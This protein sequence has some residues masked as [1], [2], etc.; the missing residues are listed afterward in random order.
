[1]STNPFA[2]NPFKERRKAGRPRK[3]EKAK[4][5]KALKKHG[6][7]LYA[8]KETTWEERKVIRSR[9]KRL[10]METTLRKLSGENV[11]FLNQ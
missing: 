8:G 11:D 4:F 3:D 1:M 6:V 5:S 7:S 10:D 2:E 9:F